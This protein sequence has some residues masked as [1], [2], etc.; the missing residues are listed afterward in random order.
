M[1]G[2]R[3]NQQRKARVAVQRRETV[4]PW[5]L[6]ALVAAGLIAAMPSWAQSTATPPV[7]GVQ[8]PAVGAA[9]Q[10]QVPEVVKPRPGQDG[11]P[12]ADQP[13]VDG[14]KPIPDSGVITPPASSAGSSAVIRP[15]ATGTMPIIPPPGSLGG[16]G[17]VVPK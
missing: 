9:P 17:G 5:W 16:Q 13:Q 15:P 8:G 11:T 12:R 1:S 14:A 3:V 6:W 7:P 2:M 4:V 10:E